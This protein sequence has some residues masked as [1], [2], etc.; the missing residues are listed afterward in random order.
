MRGPLPELIGDPIRLEQILAN[1]V[2]NAIKYTRTDAP[3]IE[4][5][6]TPR[7]DRGR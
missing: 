7:A 5:T 4:I 6:A 1:L 2:G 3:W